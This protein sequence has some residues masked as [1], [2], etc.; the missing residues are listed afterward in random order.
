MQ[1]FVRLINFDNIFVLYYGYFD[2]ED[3]LT[4]MLEKAAFFIQ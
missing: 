3:E 2:V 4:A 1:C